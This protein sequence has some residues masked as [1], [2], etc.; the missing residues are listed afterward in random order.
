M[1]S[2]ANRISV[3]IFGHVGSQLSIELKPISKRL[4]ILEIVIQVPYF[5]LFMPLYFLLDPENEVQ[6]DLP[7]S[8]HFYAS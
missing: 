6:F 7:W 1:M 3:S 5:L 2:Q 8:T 4:T